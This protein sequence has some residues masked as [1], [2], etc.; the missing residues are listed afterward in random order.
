M[1]HTNEVSH[2]II[3][4]HP[5]LPAH[6]WLKYATHPLILGTSL[7]EKMTIT[8]FNDGV[9]PLHRSN[10]LV[11]LGFCVW[12]IPLIEL[13]YSC[14]GCSVKIEGIEKMSGTITF[15]PQRNS[16]QFALCFHRLISEEEM[17]V[18]L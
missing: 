10:D 13:Q 9:F 6:A 2:V 15:W 17:L 11:E 5:V 8:S 7:R 1:I 16:M 3:V 14:N 18:R 12:I 4:V